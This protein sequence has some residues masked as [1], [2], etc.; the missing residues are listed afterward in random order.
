M[1]KRKLGN[2]D[3]LVDPLCLGANVFGWTIDEKRSFEILDT[4]FASGFNFIDTADVYSRWNSGVGGESETIIGKWMKQIKNRHKMIIA[5]K[6]GMDMGEGPN[7]SK[8]YILKMVDNSLKRLQ[9][10]Y[11]DL[12]QTHMDDDKTPV[13]ETMEAYNELVKA[14]KVRWIGASNLKPERLLASLEASQKNNFPRYET[15]QPLYNIY[16]REVY[17]KELEPICRENNISTINYY[18]LAAGFLTGKY[19]NKEDQNKSVRGARMERYM[20]ERGFKVLAVLDKVAAEYNSTSGKVAIAWLNSKPTIAAPIA[21]ATSID[22]LKDLMDASRIL[23][24]EDT[25]KLLDTETEWRD[26]A[27]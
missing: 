19:R 18:S 6:V 20:N 17:E 11:I 14:G 4:F 2:T 1:R 9:T 3:L 8:K 22:Q 10:D 12:Y 7:I 21:S 13:E 16:D 23:L 24:R 25:I 27:I 26:Q 5:T 15:L